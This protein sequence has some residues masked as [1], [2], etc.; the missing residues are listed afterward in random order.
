M[1]TVYFIRHAEADNTNRDGRARPLTEKGMSDRALVTKF[2]QDK[3]IDAI[4]SSPFRRAVDTVSDFAEQSGLEIELVED[5]CERRSDID[6]ASVDFGFEAFMQRQWADFNYTY[7]DGECLAEV[8]SRNIAALNDVLKRYSG[9]NIVI[10]TH[11]TA[12]ST[13]INYYDHTY[14]F[15][16]FMAMVNILPWVVKADFNDDGCVGMEKIN[17][18]D[19]SNKPDY[20]KCVV[21]VADCG[22]LCAYRF[23]VIFARY[24]GKWLYCRAKERDSFETP[25]GH[26]EPGETPLECA[27]RELYEETGAIRFDIV[28]AFDYSV[29]VQTVYSNGQV[30]IAWIHELGDMPD[31]EMAEVRLF[32]TIPE[33]M[34][35]PKIL[36]VVFAKAVR[37]NI[38]FKLCEALEPLPYIHAFWLE[39]ADAN[40]TAD[41]Y[42]DMD[43]WVDFEDEYEQQA[44]ETVENALSEIAA[45]D[46]KYVMHHDHPKIRQRIYHLEKTSEYLMIDFCWQLHSREQYAFHENDDVETAKVL[47]DKCGV[48][49]YKPLDLSEFSAQNKSRLEEAKYRRTQHMRA[50]K[51][52][53]RGQ[54]LEAYAYYNRYVLEP[55]IDLLRLI[56]TPAY[57]DYHL[58]HISQHIPEAKRQQLEYFAKIGSLDEMAKKMPQAAKWFD[59]LVE[60]I[61]KK[62]S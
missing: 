33:K 28:P 42:S 32:D 55:L 58:I 46:Y 52:V 35:F 10:G 20:D 2:L 51:Y 11:G 16:D 21:R 38:I 62:E 14:G 61:E 25:G 59:E 17:L 37:E 7:S 27:K 53:R 57:A 4:L 1:T 5:F 56:Y 9:K 47:F 22:A 24:K 34:R 40:G 60:N 49:R 8:Q 50:E 13:I 15:A 41:E 29:H 23:T 6:F 31:F 48:V 36:P 45:I 39:G 26:I 12:L 44:Y 3:G 18:F 43:F 19:P 54:Y 30:Y